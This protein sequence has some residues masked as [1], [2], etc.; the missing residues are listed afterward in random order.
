MVFFSIVIPTYNRADLIG[1]TIKSV[2]NQTFKNW[3]CIIVDDGS[4]DNT[5]EVVSKISLVDNRVKYIHQSNAERSAARNKGIK[6]AIG[7]YICFLDSDDYFLENHLLEMKKKIEVSS[8]KIALF[9]SNYIYSYNGIKENIVI[10]KLTKNTQHY[11]VYNPIIPARVCIHN[12]ILKEF[13]FDED[14]VI[15]ED[16]LLWLKISYKYPLFHLELDTIIYNI[17]E[18]N[19]VNIKN[20][21]AI[22]R[23]NGLKVF[24]KRYPNIKLELP[25]K[26]YNFLIGDTCF[27]IMKYYIY[28]Q[29]KLKSI[30]YL[31]LS[32]FYQKNHNQ[33]KHKMLIL[34]YLLINK[35]IKEYSK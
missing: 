32:I 20:N 9:F 2:I 25:K 1:E 34:V 8:D 31:L 19:S 22:K 5:K 16:F 29:N 18:D 35:Q 23:L 14:I 6:N 28:H 24:F 33:L 21:A 4:L 7:K 12:S 3:E 13:Q 10:P 15:V 26:Y 30:K 11:L 17:H 27:S